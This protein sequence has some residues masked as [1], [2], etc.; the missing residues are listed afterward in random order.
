MSDASYANALKFLEEEG[1]INYLIPS[2]RG[3]EEGCFQ[4]ADKERLENLCRRL[5][6]FL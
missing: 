6:N 1:I 4:L 2:G 5:S 3:T